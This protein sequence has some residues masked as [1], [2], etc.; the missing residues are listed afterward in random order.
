METPIFDPRKKY[1]WEPTDVFPLS[2][3]EFTIVLN[4]TRAILNTPEAR[5]VLFAQRANEI[6]E[7]ALEK[8][9]KAGIVKEVEEP[10]AEKNEIK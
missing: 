9:I 10:K 1:R 7:N 8:A 2:G 6:A 5:L 4:A 3:N